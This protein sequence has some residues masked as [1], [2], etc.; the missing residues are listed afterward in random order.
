[1][2]LQR[3]RSS[4]GAQSPTPSSNNPHLTPQ[5]EFHGSKSKDFF[6]R[7]DLQAQRAS[8]AGASTRVGGGGGWGA[9]GREHL[10]PR[11]CCFTGQMCVAVCGGV[12][13][14]G[15]AGA[16]TASLLSWGRKAEVRGYTER[17]TSV[18][19]G[20]SECGRVGVVCE[21]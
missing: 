13:G 9:P 7:I 14:E 21:Y 16:K 20:A 2:T 6:W 11:A 18:G 3:A 19:S 8:P 5:R 4:E 10:S 1:M 12:G 17:G 15:E